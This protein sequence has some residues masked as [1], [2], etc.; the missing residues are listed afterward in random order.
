MVYGVASNS[1]EI[2]LILQP[3]RSDVKIGSALRMGVGHYPSSIP[4]KLIDLISV[5]GLSL[6][7]YDF[8]KLQYNHGRHMVQI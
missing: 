1:L 6:S 8:M 2:T 5:S 3:A 7:I 4:A